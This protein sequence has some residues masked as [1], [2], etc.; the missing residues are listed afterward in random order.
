[1]LFVGRVA[2]LHPMDPGAVHSM[3]GGFVVEDIAETRAMLAAVLGE[4][5][6]DIAVET[7]VDLRTARRW[8]AGLAGDGTGLIALIDLGLPDGSGIELI[9]E[10]RRSHPAAQVVVTTIYDDDAHLFEA[11]AAGAHGYLLKDRDA[12]EMAGRL[13]SIGDGDAP[14]S[15][16]IARRILEHFRARAAEMRDAASMYDA[17]TPR[18]T[19][20][21]RLISRGL[22]LRE[23]GAILESS[24][25]TVATHVKNLYRKLGISSRAEAALHAARLDL[26]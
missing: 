1:M 12:R 20:V 6:G 23:A 11:M 25:Q 18:E 15:P 26:A 19:E 5:F 22:T 9:E 13:R 10:L 8:M 3:V 2:R 14:I 17:L 24:S 7:A 4:A 16:P 21:L